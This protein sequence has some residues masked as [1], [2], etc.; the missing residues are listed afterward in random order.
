MKEGFFEKR[1]IMV[2][3]AILCCIFWGTAF[4]CIKI[5]Y[6]LF[7]ISGEYPSQILFA[8]ERFL[9]AGIIIVLFMWIQERR[10]VLPPKN[11]I[12]IIIVIGLL[13][14]V[15]QY[16]LFY[17]GLGNTTAVKGSIISGCVGFFSILI[18]AVFI[19]SDRLTKSKI[20]GCLLGFAGVVAVNFDGLEGGLTVN[21]LG[22]GLL[23]ASTISAAFANLA[24]KKATRK[25]DAVM[26]SG[27]QFIAGGIIMIAIGFAMG[28]N[29]E[30]S[31][32]S[33]VVLM[34]YMACISS[35]AYT[36][37]NVL[38][39]HNDISK[40]VIFDF[41]VPV[42]GVI[43]SAMFLPEAGLTM[44]CLIALVLV[45]MGIYMINRR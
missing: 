26:I 28:G 31:G 21:W 29:L 36:L 38:L 16:A 18:A 19:K 3:C 40:V 22:D 10:V 23:L 14:T 7:D 11:A 5:G 24:T 45:S 34:L 35:V 44:A 4:P 42:M 41:A 17:I 9:L 27:Y 33:S 32:V 15:I 43:F 6:Q 20:I 37:W 13:L 1:K 12:P 8:G 39:K 25:Y 30:Y 2:P